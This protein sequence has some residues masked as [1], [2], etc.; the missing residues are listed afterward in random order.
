MQKCL[1]ERSAHLLKEWAEKQQ[2]QEP[3]IVLTAHVCAPVL[4]RI[5]FFNGETFVVD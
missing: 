2:G 3:T 4:T 1:I 5:P